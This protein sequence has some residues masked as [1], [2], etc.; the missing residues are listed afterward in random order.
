MNILILGSTGLIGNFL[1]QKFNYHQN[2]EI[3]SL[4][5]KKFNRKNHFTFDV[6]NNQNMQMLNH[7][8][9]DIIFNCLGY[10]A[11]N[12]NVL[13]FYKKLAK[14]FL[15]PNAIWVEFGTL[16]SFKNKNL[17][18]NFNL[19]NYGQN[20]IISENFIKNLSLINNF[21][22]VILKLGATCLKNDYND[23][24]YKKLNK[25]IYFNLFFNFYH[26]K[27]IFFKIT[28]LED[29]YHLCNKIIND[30]SINYS[31][32]VY[33]RN[34]NPLVCLRKINV[35]LLIFK[36]NFTLVSFILKFLNKNL[37]IKFNNI[38]N[39]KIYDK[40]TSG[41]NYFIIK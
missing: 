12:D 17:S 4:S 19:T 2:F 8:K 1:F 30:R 24:I 32:I 3:F 36:I 29:I 5:R 39:F 34:F 40:E 27:H 41:I 18:S 15:T 11:N 31:I 33:F 10:N 22:L 16:S 20:K 35:N 6:I 9:F 23:F 21:K 13:K 28:F 7:Y 37:F 14:K 25:I 38:F 26:D